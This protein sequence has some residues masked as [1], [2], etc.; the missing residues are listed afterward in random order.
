MT[1]IKDGVF[2]AESSSTSGTGALTL[3]G[4]VS[5]FNTFGSI[6]SDAEQCV[7]FVEDGNGSD[8]FYALGT[9]TASGTIL[10]RDTILHS[11]NAGANVTLSANTH[12][13]TIEPIPGYVTGLVDY[14]EQVLVNAQLKSYSEVLQ[15]PS[16]SSGTLTLDL[17][18]G[19]N[20]HVTLTENV[21]T[22]TISNAK[23]SGVSQNFTLKL[24]QGGAGS[25]T[26]APLL[27]SPYNFD[28]GT[29]PTLVTTAGEYDRLAVISEDGGTAWDLFHSGGAF[30]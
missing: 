19:N 16:S 17:A 26:I 7:Y 13:V 28:G 29:A 9:Y 27:T 5:G 22:L 15:T 24:E 6:L 11:S 30:A 21:T 1:D 8:Y 20:F 4:A 10:S 12:T 2:I 14:L 23:A 25:F 18:T 3:G